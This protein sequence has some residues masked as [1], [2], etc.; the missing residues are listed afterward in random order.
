MSICSRTACV[1]LQR[2]N[3]YRDSPRGA[4]GMQRLGIDLE[5]LARRGAARSALIEQLR[6]TDGT[7]VGGLPDPLIVLAEDRGVRRANSAARAAFWGRHAS[8]AAPSRAARRDRPCVR[9]RDDTDRRGDVAG[10]GAA[11]RSMR[12]WC[13]WTRRS[14]M[15]AAP[16]W[17][18]RTARESD[19]VERMRADFVAM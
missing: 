16:W 13:R 4:P 10:A 6:R 7:V 9:L 8:G 2:M 14:P 19:A 17:C 12:P 18:C 15:A 11:R 5:R 1:A 3:P